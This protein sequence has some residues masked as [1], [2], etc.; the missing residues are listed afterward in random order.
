MSKRV[1]KTGGV[2]GGHLLRQI[3]TFVGVLV[4]TLILLTLL[5]FAS[6]GVILGREEQRRIEQMTQVMP[7]ATVFSQT[8]FEDPRVDDVQAA[9][10]GST[11]LGY[12][13]T[14][15]TQGFRGPVVTVTGVDV[16]GVVTGTVVIEHEESARLGDAIESPDFLSGF[17]GHS[18]TLHIGAGSNGVTGITGATESAGAVLEGVNIALNCVANLDLEG[19][20]A[21]EGDL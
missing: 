19:G 15:T 9:Y 10:Q 13:V 7:G 20:S 8:W 14:V 11:L 1:V 18:G 16:N 12:C 6:T 21:H 2:D 4:F 5:H 17:I 3:V